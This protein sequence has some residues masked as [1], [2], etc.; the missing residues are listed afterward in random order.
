MFSQIGSQITRIEG[1]GVAGKGDPL[2]A[3]AA[4]TGGAYI[5]SED[6]LKKPFRR[7]V[8]DL[9]TYY[10][11][12][13]VPPALDY[14]GEFR[15]VTVKT[16]RRGLTVQARAGYFAVPPS[17][18]ARPF[19]APLMKLLSEPLLPADL[20]FRATVFQL[21]K[22]A[23]GNENTLVVEVPIS[24]LQA[25]NDFN[26]NLLSWHV[27]M[28]SEIKDKSGTVVE[29]FSED[30]PGHGALDTKEEE[31]GYATMQR[32][33]TL[34]P[35]KYTLET[36]VVDR[37]N[38]KLGA[39]RTNFE[40]PDVASGP[41]L[42]DVVLVRRID[43]S[44]DELDPL[45]PLRYKEGKVVPSLS[46]QVQILPG[47][48]DLTFFFLVHSDSGIPEP[49]MLEMQVL[50]NGELL[51]QMPL[52]LPK[53]LG[54][55]FPYVASL[56]TKS[57]RPGKYDLRLSLVQGEHIIERE[58]SFSIGGAEL[59]SAALGKTEPAGPGK[60][61]LE[62]ADSSPGGGEILPAGRQSL[63][64]TALPPGS[65]TRPSD[66][67]LARIVTEPKNMPSIIR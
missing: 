51:G 41:F 23:T 3:M 25:N 42:S 2:A 19:E 59:A 22:L 14:N 52:Q 9:T 53:D 34:P 24:K 54:D 1:E 50:R 65:V 56:G 66:D 16:L 63:V 31:R 36:A 27:S 15:P 46:G 49:A 67:E 38:E 45:E 55:V 43:S 11:A 58:S 6:N 28:V 4:R 48:K 7:A 64:I 12:S 13:Y 35:G 26:A 20:Q 62:I 21:G 60:E 44:S 33:F 61:A 39:E 40:V 57:L 47:T 32:H 10:E 29:H 5:Y 37:N 17:G 8:A 30:I 18:V